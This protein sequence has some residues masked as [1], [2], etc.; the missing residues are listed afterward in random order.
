MPP[1]SHLAEDAIAF[2][3]VLHIMWTGAFV[4]WSDLLFIS[5]TNMNQAVA[6][7][8]DLGPCYWLGVR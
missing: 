6:R 8:Q 2:L 3:M 5:L 4:V 1:V 7:L